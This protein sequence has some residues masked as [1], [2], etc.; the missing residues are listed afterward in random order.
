M[1]K[2]LQEAQSYSNLAMCEII[3]GLLDVKFGQTKNI[4][5][6]YSIIERNV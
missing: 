6:R 5:V 2:N 4:N 3:I 1:A